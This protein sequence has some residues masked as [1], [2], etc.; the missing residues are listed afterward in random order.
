MNQLPVPVLT[1]LR[2]VQIHLSAQVIPGWAAVPA[3]TSRLTLAAEG[4]ADALQA[5]TRFF[6]GSWLQDSETPEF[7]Q[8]I[9]ALRPGQGV[10]LREE[11]QVIRQG[12]RLHLWS[13]MTYFDR[14]AEADLDFSEVCEVIRLNLHFWTLR[15]EWTAGTARR[16]LPSYDETRGFRVRLLRPD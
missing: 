5:V 3:Y 15:R 16:G 10:N 6:Q 13:E 14:T 1:G 4:P 8:A 11:G 7:L 2:L 12:D 9:L